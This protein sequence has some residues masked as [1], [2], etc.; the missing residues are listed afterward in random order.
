MTRSQR[1]SR[2]NGK[3]ALALPASQFVLGTL[4]LIVHELGHGL[5]AVLLGGTFVRWYLAPAVV[6]YATYQMPVDSIYADHI[7]S[8]LITA[9]GV[10]WT[11]LFWG[12]T[13]MI[14]NYELYRRQNFILSSIALGSVWGISSELAYIGIGPII[15]WGDGYELA[16][17][18]SLWVPVTSV[19]LLAL[20]WVL[21][22]FPFLARTLRPYANLDTGPRLWAFLIAAM[23]PNAL[24]ATLKAEIFFPE[25]TERKL[26][27]MAATII[28]LIVITFVGWPLTRNQWRDP[29]VRPVYLS[30]WTTLV[31]VFLVVAVEFAAAWY[32]GL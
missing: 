30:G 6:G 15:K 4:G 8:G 31:L 14:V 11:I 10:F 3:L 7:I 28:G 9:G 23:L 1:P 19:I 32:F 27:F 24:Y 12:I 13:A 29:G 2:F 16:Q 25:H 21:F 5:T 17:E 26:I 22:G 20:F 18:F